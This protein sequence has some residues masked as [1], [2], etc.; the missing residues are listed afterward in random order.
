MQVRPARASDAVGWAEQIKAVADEGRWIATEGDRTVEDI[1]ERFRSADAEDQIMLVLEDAGRIVGGIGIHPTG[2]EG[3]HT[4][5]M[6]ILKEFRGQGWGRQLV[7]A[8]LQEAR[9]RGIVKVVLEVWPDNG[10]AIALY[11]SAGFEIE[12]YKRHH[13]PRLDGSRRSAVMMALFL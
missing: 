6:S 8:A 13:Y 7:A 10:R 1:A 4:L 5:G 3:V 11:A 12:G 2:I 9:G